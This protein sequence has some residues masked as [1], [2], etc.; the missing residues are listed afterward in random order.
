MTNQAN[1]E[2]LQRKP[3]FRPA[4]VI[5]SVLL[6]LIA[7]SLSAQWYANQVTL[8]RYCEDPVMTLARVERLLNEREPAGDGDRKPFIIAARLTFLIPRQPEES[9]REYLTRL[10]QHMDQQCR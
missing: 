4:K 6:I 3:P 2:Q 10:Q 8:P 7:I 5:G 1:I 9:V